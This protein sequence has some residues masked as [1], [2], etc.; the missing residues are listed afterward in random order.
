MDDTTED[1]IMANQDPITGAYYNYEEGSS[2]NTDTL[3]FNTRLLAF[4]SVC[5]YVNDIVSVLPSLP[6]NGDRYAHGTY[7]SAY[8]GAAWFTITAKEGYSLLNKATG[9]QIVFDGTLWREISSPDIIYAIAGTSII[10]HTAVVIVNGEVFPADV[11]NTSHIN[12]VVGI[13]LNSVSSG[14]QVKI[15]TSGVL[16]ESSF[17]FVSG[18]AVFI[19]LSGALT[20]TIPEA[21][22]FIYQV[23]SATK[24]TEINIS[25][26]TPIRRA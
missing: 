9:R 6:A 8:M 18:T 16:A 26:K 5:P 11:T 13:A 17:S 19:G 20:Q 12:A 25:L 22:V 14:G 15:Q 3:N 2:G 21:A 4:F 24:T 10:S 23:G 7:L 1:N